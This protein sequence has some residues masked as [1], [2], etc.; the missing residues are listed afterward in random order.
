MGKFTPVTLSLEVSSNQLAVLEDIHEALEL[1]TK[2]LHRCIPNSFRKNVDD[3]IERIVESV[4]NLEYEWKLW[5]L[6]EFKTK[7]NSVEFFKGI[8]IQRINPWDVGHR[9]D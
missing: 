4:E 8:G 3:T 1:V 5:V 6:E 7:M 9:D 2:K